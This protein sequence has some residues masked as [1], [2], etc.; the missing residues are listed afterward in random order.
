M[1]ILNQIDDNGH[2]FYP[3]AFEPL[4]LKVNNSC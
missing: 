2:K 4:F 3:Q 1:I